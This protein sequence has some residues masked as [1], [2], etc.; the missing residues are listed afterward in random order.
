MRSVADIEAKLSE[1][2]FNYTR[3]LDMLA[4]A[5]EQWV[6]NFLEGVCESHK[7]VIKTLK[8]ILQMEE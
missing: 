4:K 3:N 5:K 6:K 1:F 2:E 7:E 8:W